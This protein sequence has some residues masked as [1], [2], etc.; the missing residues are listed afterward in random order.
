MCEVMQISRSLLVS[1]LIH[2]FLSY[3]MWRSLARMTYIVFLIHLNFILMFFYSMT[4]TVE[5]TDIVLVSPQSH[6]C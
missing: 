1:G 2:S 5:A 4:Y 3:G 6:C